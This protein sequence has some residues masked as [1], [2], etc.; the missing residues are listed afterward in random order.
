VKLRNKVRSGA[1]AA[2]VAI[3]LSTDGGAQTPAASPSPAGTI[4]GAWTLNK[5]L[6]DQPQFGRQDD[7]GGRRG[8]Y[9]RGGGMGGGFGRRGGGMGRGGYGGGGGSQ[10]PEEIQRRREAM[11]EIMT[12]P[13]RLTI[14]Q[15]DNMIVITTGDGRVT[16]LSPDGKKVKD[17]NTKIERRTKWDGDKLVSEVNGVGSGKITETYALER[18]G[19]PRPVENEHHQLIVTV[20]LDNPRSGQPMTQRRVYDAD[21]K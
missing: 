5:D 14:V 16:R 6:S 15:A 21:A 20:A 18:G 3:G 13:D 4:A 7:N 8:G 17:D 2:V 11:R 19:N 10:D 1:L 9:G 12:P